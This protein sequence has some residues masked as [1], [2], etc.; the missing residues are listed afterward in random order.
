MATTTRPTTGTRTTWARGL[1]APRGGRARSAGGRR[2]SFPTSPSVPAAPA[3]GLSR[4]RRKV[5]NH[6][7]VACD[8]P[9]GWRRGARMNLRALAAADP[10]TP[11][12]QRNC[13]AVPIGDL[14]EIRIKDG[15]A[16]YCGLE[17]CGNVWLCPVCSAKIH[18]RR[19]AELRDALDSLGGPGNAATLV[20]I[21]VPHDLDDRLSVLLDAQKDAWKHVT[22]G[23]PGSGSRSGSGSPATSSPW[24]SPG[25]MRTAG[26]PTTTS[27]WSTTRTSTPPPLR[28]CTPT[29]TPGSAPP[30][31]TTGSVRRASCTPSGSTPTSRPPLPVLTSPRAASGHRPRK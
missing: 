14:V 27:S 25:A 4:Y 31:A 20:T 3:H 7:L 17:T 22:P 21:T 9:A 12:R 19:A 18:H 28:R 11:M 2:S 6:P 24:S 15:S 10:D 13:G 29:S 16:Y 1:G 8:D 5:T 30:A 23:R 26:I